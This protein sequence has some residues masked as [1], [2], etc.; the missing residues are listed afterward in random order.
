[1]P[2]KF[3][4][5]PKNFWDD[6]N[7]QRKFIDWAGKQLNINDMSDWYKLT[8]KVFDC[9]LF[10]AHMS[11]SFGDVGSTLLQNKYNGSLALMLSTLY[12]EYDWLPWKFSKSP[13]NFWED[14]KNQRKFMDWAGKQLR[15][16]EMSDWYKVSQ[17]V[18]NAKPKSV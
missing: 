1:L 10:L 9:V 4:V 16:K 8:A 12:P 11:Q 13:L 6:V 18:R 3:S 17:K 7:N 14:V 2:W 5:C 15:I